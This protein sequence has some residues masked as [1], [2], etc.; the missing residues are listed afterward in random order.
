M[1][2]HEALLAAVADAVHAPSIFNTQP[3]QWAVGPTSLTLLADP[4]RQLAVVDPDRNLMRQSCGAALHHAR[5]CLAAAGWA[6]EVD[7]R[8][9]DRPLLAHVEIVGPAEPDLRAMA[10]REAI[11]RRRT[12]RRPF[13]DEPVPPDL[14]AAL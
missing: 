2:E 13:T 8:D 5:I 12:D 3:W 9:D 11:A 6:V 10:L 1:S 4:S 7:R 14:L